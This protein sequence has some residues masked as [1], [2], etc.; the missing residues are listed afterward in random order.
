MYTFIGDG[1]QKPPQINVTVSPGTMIYHVLNTC[2][3]VFVNDITT[4]SGNGPDIQFM[5]FVLG[6]NCIACLPLFV[7]NQ[8][9]LGVL[10]LGFAEPRGWP[11]QERVRETF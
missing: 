2:K 6:M 8:R 7:A 10:R 1:V 5:R 4:F 11:E 3:P 9:I